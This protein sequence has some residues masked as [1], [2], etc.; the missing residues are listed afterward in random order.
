MTLNYTDI[1]A[2]I[3]AQEDT[4]EFKDLRARFRDLGVTKYDYLVDKGMYRY[5]DNAN[6][7]LDLKLNGVIKEVKDTSDQVAL[8]KAVQQAQMGKIDFEQFCNLA[9]QAGVIYWQTNLINNTIT[10]F[11]K[12]GM[13]LKEDLRY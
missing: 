11:N 2:A 7:T 10:F 5:Y 4:G 6:N 9:G 12:A 13:I 3:N 8:E 1:K